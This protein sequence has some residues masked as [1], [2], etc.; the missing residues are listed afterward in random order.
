MICVRDPGAIQACSV[1]NKS[2]KQYFVCLIIFLT[3]LCWILGF[4]WQLNFNDRN[5]SL[6][7]VCERYLGRLHPQLRISACSNKVWNLVIFRLR[8]VEKCRNGWPTAVD[9][10][11]I[12]NRIKQECKYT[13][14]CCF[15]LFIWN[16]S[17]FYLWWTND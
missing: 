7:E 4:C 13:F 15:G 8:V 2:F 6:Q 12:R 5:F 11:T 1:K 10:R 3:S 17:N 9:C 16:V 14:Y